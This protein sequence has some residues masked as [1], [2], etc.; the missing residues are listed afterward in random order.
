MIH[1]IARSLYEKYSEHFEMC[2]NFNE[3]N[4]KLINMLASGL[5][6]EQNYSEYLEKR[7]EQC[8]KSK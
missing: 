6:Q 5:E 7:L 4:L 1:P 8:E 2:S 3:V